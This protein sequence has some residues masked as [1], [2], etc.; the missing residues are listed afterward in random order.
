MQNNPSSLAQFS[1]QI[2]SQIDSSIDKLSLIKQKL[3]QFETKIQSK[4]Q[5]MELLTQ[6]INTEY[7]N[8]V[9][10]MGHMEEQL[11]EFTNQ[12]QNESVELSNVI[13]TQQQNQN[14]RFT[15]VQAQSDTLK[16]ELVAEIIT[17]GTLRNQFDQV[18]RAGIKDY[19]DEQQ[20]LSHVYHALDTTANQM[21]GNFQK[22]RKMFADQYHDLDV[23]IDTMDS[24]IL[25]LINNASQN[26]HSEQ[27]NIDQNFQHFSETIQNDINQLI[28]KTTHAVQA[29]V[30]D[31]IEEALD[32]LIKK[33][34]EV[35]ELQSG[36]DKISVSRRI[37]KEAIDE[38]KSTIDIVGDGLQ[39]AEEFLNQLEDLINKLQ[40]PLDIFS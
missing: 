30:H 26:I 11:N 28:A 21:I 5:D 38:L 40:N 37:I 39:P 4:I 17:F 24:T 9:G 13:L 10:F 19:Q 16:S 8:F 15:D 20:K 1:Q 31:L 14:Q 34:L 2:P 36:N 7:A 29:D 3:S 23:A 18:I 6:K 32:R 27:Y 12:L 35:N 22:H 25:T 33:L